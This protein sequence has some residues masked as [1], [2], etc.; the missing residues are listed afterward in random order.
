MRSQPRRAFCAGAFL[1][2]FLARDTLFCLYDEVSYPG[3]NRSCATAADTVREECDERA[4]DHRENEAGEDRDP[5][6][7]SVQEWREMP[8]SI[9]LTN[10]L[11]VELSRNRRIPNL[12]SKF[13][14]S[15]DLK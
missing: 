10:R 5:L 4:G 8:T 9:Q 3:R 12:R 14:L 2:D 7:S 15:F 13:P 11:V 6:H 1:M